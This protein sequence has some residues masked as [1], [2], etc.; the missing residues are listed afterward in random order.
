MASSTSPEEPSP[1]TCS[2]CP[3][4]HRSSSPPPE[5]SAWPPTGWGVD[6]RPEPAR[7]PPALTDR[8]RPMHLLLADLARDR[9]AELAQDVPPPA[10]RPARTRPTAAPVRRAVLARRPRPAQPRQRGGR[11]PPRRVPRRRPARP[12]ARPMAP[13]LVSPVDAPEA[14]SP[15]CSSASSARTTRRVVQ[16]RTVGA[17]ARRSCASAGDRLRDRPAPAEWSVIECLGHLV[18]WRARGQRAGPL[19]PGRGRAG[20][21]RLRPGSLGRPAAPSRR[22]SRASSSRCSRPCAR[23]TCACGRRRPP[24][25]ASASVSTASAGPRATT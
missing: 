12:A 15:S 14:L 16:G 20:H 6:S 24:R 25:P 13:D 22:R 19:D 23:P 9:E 2:S 17:D 8:T 21:R 7:R 1:W 11:P 5:P 4:R 18:D 10:T 3:D